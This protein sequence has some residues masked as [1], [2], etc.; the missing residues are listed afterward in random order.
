M[1]GRIATPSKPEESNPSASVL[2]E[3]LKPSAVRLVQLDSPGSGSLELRI[4]EVD[5]KLI[6]RTQDLAG[7]FE[8]QSSQWKE[9]QQR[10]EASGIVLMPIEAP[11]RGA[12]APV[13][14]QIVSAD[15][16]H[17]VCYETG[18]GSSGRDRSGP[19][20]SSGRARAF[21]ESAHRDSSE[22]PDESMKTAEAL[23]VSR[24]WYHRLPI[25]RKAEA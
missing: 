20:S 2:H 17:T 10:L 3:T 8:G 19:R 21:G 11:F 24:Q 23:P 25:E 6:I 1:D 16:R 18:M 22:S 14:S 9:L 5:E 15:S 4:Q 7:S 13:E 12:A